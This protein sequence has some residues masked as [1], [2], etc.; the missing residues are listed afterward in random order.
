MDHITHARAS[1][2]KC[3]PDARLIRHL[4][5]LDINFDCASAVEMDL[6]LRQGVPPSSVIF[7]NPC[8]AKS[9]IRHARKQGV[10]KTTFDNA[11]ELVKLA[12][13]FPDAHLVL[14]I[15][16]NDATATVHL[17][18][19]FG[20]SV[21]EAVALLDLAREL[22]L[23]VIGISFHVGS[24]TRDVEPFKLALRDAHHLWTYAERQGFRMCLL[25]IGGGSTPDN[26]CTMAPAINSYLQDYF[27][28]IPCQIIAEPGRYFAAGAYTLAC[29]VIA[30]RTSEGASEPGRIYLS[31]GVFGS[32]A[33]CIYEKAQYSPR[34]LCHGDEF[35]PSATGA[36]EY[37]IWGPTCDSADC[38]NRQCHLD[39]APGVGD[40]VYFEDMGGKR[41]SS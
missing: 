13:E 2:V 12:R 41:Q 8:K 16:A 23:N 18:E 34:M 19:K 27:G 38:I 15:L 37:S 11:A 33:N 10:L 4:A 29:S 24:G 21:S 14:R 31:D 5:A 3:N 9:A 39:H 30:A 28:Q 40:W 32:F 36:H 35:F 22:E 25:D 17:S 20:A 26:L 7:A 6:V 1:A